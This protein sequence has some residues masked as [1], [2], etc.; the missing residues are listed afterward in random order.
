MYECTYISDI[1]P[2]WGA[3]L[4]PV[5]PVRLR[6]WRG[7]VAGNSCRCLLP[8][9]LSLHHPYITMHSEVGGHLLHTAHFDTLPGGG[10]P[11]IKGE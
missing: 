3:G 9:T 5:L 1:F 6:P 7:C 8:S 2:P 11:L 10:S 4:G